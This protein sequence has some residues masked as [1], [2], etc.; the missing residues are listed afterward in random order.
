MIA[1]A[2]RHP[3]T[4]L[5]SGG[6][7]RGWSEPWIELPRDDGPAASGE[8][9][10]ARGV[11]EWA[12]LRNPALLS[13]HATVVEWIARTRPLFMVVDGSVEVSLLA[14]LCGIPVIVIATP[15]IRIERAREIAYDLAHRI[16]APWPEEACP[17]PWSK[18]WR[19]KT[20]HV[21]GIC[22]FDADVGR[23]RETVQSRGDRRQ[24][25]MLWGP[26]DNDV[27]RS[28]VARAERATPRWNWV[29]R[30]WTDPA[31]IE[32]WDDLMDSDVVITHAS[33]DAVADVACA[34]RPAIVLAQARSDDA[35]HAIASAV[36]R[37][38]VARGL[39]RWADEHEWPA[40]LDE[41]LTRGGEVWRRWGSDGAPFA[42]RC[43]D[44]AAA[45][46][47]AMVAEQ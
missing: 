14:R 47:A 46:A 2:M 31:G 6:P 1:K 5:G 34:R 17:S 41:A 13:R 29:H 11:L 4:G 15:A 16:V 37:L 32:C 8:D 7:P 42:A 35:Q 19:A 38:G 43:L 9:I 40:L 28:E 24:V 21:G 3:V 36:Q 22:R 26:G 44:E 27:P 20:W 39:S 10:D 23:P 18:A 25:L 45:A 12:P 30:E 33:P